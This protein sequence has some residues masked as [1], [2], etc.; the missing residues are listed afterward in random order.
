[1]RYTTLIELKIEK[2]YE[3]L[4]RG[5]RKYVVNLNVF[6]KKTLNRLG[7]EETYLTI[8]KAV[9]G[10]C[11]PKSILNS[12]ICWDWEQDKGAHTHNSYSTQY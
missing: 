6:H 11:T 9:W 3:P 10:Q 4:N 12:E 5:R 1:M 7:L 2:S 8:I